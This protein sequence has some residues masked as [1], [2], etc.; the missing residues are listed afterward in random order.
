MNRVQDF[1]INVL[2][3]GI[4]FALGVKFG[5]DVFTKIKK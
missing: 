4:S 2:L 1:I 3:G 5:K